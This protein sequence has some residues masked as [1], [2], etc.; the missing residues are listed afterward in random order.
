M[1]AKTAEDFQKELTVQLEKQV[2]QVKELN[3]ATSEESKAAVKG[4]E[5]NIEE[6][7]TT[8]DQVKEMVKQGEAS[9]VSGIEEV[10]KD[11]DMGNFV[12]A[13]Y[14]SAT[15]QQNPW[16]NAGTEKEIIDQHAIAKGANAGTGSE[17]AY[18]IPEEVTSPITTYAI[19]NTPILNENMGTGIIR[20]LTGTLSLPKITGKNTAYW[21]GENVKPTESD[22]V[23]GEDKLAPRKLAAFTKISNRLLRMSKGVA[24]KEIMNSLGM[25]LS[26]EMND[27]LS[28]A[29]GSD[30]KPTGIA[31][32]S[33][34]MTANTD[35]LQ[36]VI[37][38]NA[39][40]FKIDDAAAM[41]EAIEVANKL[42]NGG[43]YS[44]YMR[45]EV[46]AGMK[47]ERVAQYS[48]QPEAEAAAL[49]VNPLMS[50][51]V[52]EDII[53]YGIKTST[54]LS[55]ATLGTSTTSSTVLFGDWSKFTVGLWKDLEIK[56]SDTAGDGSTGSA[57]LQDQL[58]VVAFQEVDS[59]LRDP[60]AFTSFV[61]AET[62]ASDW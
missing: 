56:V 1:S 23:W 20:N 9:R 8:I 50:R 49:M 39:R 31:S 48:G 15:N 10:A 45:P 37:G 19:A 46:L 33:S 53:G 52:L 57:F 27:A 21:V 38:A 40:R 7:K 18:T 61:G 29:V 4:V 2:E 51:K 24:Q 59:V 54:S 13:L 34:E 41:E 17:G 5:A 16:K 47:R 14:L 58:Y 44:F 3:T 36:T 60:A 25:A 12:N 11:F 32:Y 30:Y 26:E 42:K 35:Y 22:V 28:V 43:K 62:K 6:L 55:K